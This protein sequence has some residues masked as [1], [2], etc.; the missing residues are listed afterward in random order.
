MFDLGWSELAVVALVALIVVGPRELPE[1][2]RTIGKWV[3]KARSMAR[4]FQTSVDDMV[5]EAE[6]DEARKTMESA[7]HLDIGK[8]IENSIDPTGSVK[9]EMAELDS[10][11]RR[12][13][14]GEDE[15]PPEFRE[16]ETG[17]DAAGATVEEAGDKGATVIEQPAQP[18][19]PHSITPPEATPAEAPK[20]AGKSRKQSA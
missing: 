10:A 1:V 11:A 17:A 7:R 20:A 5:R 8:E 14:K 9:E 15:V 2:L 3:R 4:E 13:A 19:P 16:E 6:L 18:A 12:A